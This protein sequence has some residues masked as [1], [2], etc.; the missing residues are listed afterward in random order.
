MDNKKLSIFA[1]IKSPEASES[2]SFVLN[3]C[4]R[5]PIEKGFKKPPGVLVLKVYKLKSIPT[6]NLSLSSFKRSDRLKPTQTELISSLTRVGRPVWTNRFRTGPTYLL[7]NS[8]SRFETVGNLMMHN[9]EGSQVLMS[10]HSSACL[11][12]RT[13]IFSNFPIFFDKLNYVWFHLL[14]SLE[15]YASIGKWSFVISWLYRR[16]KSV[17]SV[18]EEEPKKDQEFRNCS[19]TPHQY[20]LCGLSE[21]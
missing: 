12:L 13:A 14:K 8:K 3:S 2:E 5:E 16:L 6:P 4:S 10:L 21:S 11:T 1:K 20:L 17:F 19:S 18:N 9:I 7:L 15:I